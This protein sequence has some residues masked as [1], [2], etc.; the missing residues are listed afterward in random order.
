MENRKER[1]TNQSVDN[2]IFRIYHTKIARVPTVGYTGAPN[3]S[4]YRN[5]IGY[6]NFDKILEKERLIKLG[7]GKASYAD[8]PGK[9]QESL[10]IVTPDEE[11]GFVSG[12]KG[13]KPG[14]KANNL[15]GA[16]TSELVL[17]SK[18][19]YKLKEAF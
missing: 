9:F 4:I 12:Y 1:N 16:N 17:Q 14:I 5:Q 2:N 18:N 3:E 6:L 15:Y 7:P 19:A 13:Y 8:L 10:K 11:C